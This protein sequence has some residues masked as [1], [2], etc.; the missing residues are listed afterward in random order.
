MIAHAD[1]AVTKPSPQNLEHAPRQQ[2]EKSC[3]AFAGILDDGTI[4]CWGDLSDDLTPPTLPEGKKAVSVASTTDALD[5]ISP[6]TK[7][8]SPGSSI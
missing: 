4:Q 5:T 2:T 8:L 6:V 3:A 7:V 1:H